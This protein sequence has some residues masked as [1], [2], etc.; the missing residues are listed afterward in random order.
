MSESH[1][2]DGA[3]PAPRHDRPRTAGYDL[4]RA[5]AL[6]GMCMVDVRGSLEVGGR[7]LEPLVWLADCL[8]G[9]AAAL[10]VVLAGIGISLRTTRTEDI[11]AHAPERRALLERAGILAGVGALLVHIWPSDILH[12][13]A[14]Y[15]LLALPLLQASSRTLWL[16]SGASMWIAMVLQHDLDWNQ[17]SPASPVGMLRHLSFSGLYPV[18]PWIAFVL[19]GMVVGRLELAD[20]RIRRRTLAIALT[21]ATATSMLDA[22]GCWDRDSGVLGLG[23]HAAWLMTWPRAP[24]PMFVISGCAVAVSVVCVCISLGER[25]R[26]RT[27]VTALVATGQL[28]L[29]LYVAHVLAIVVPLEHGLLRGL[30]IELAHAYA[31]AFYAVAIAFAL[32]WRRRWALGPLEGLMRQVIARDRDQP[33]RGAGLRGQ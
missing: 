7:G 19:V 4:A 2:D 5:A 27:W 32:W 11:Q 14:V 16:L 10:F 6:L 29:S 3:E 17:P 12:F 33:A 20:R 21:I 31:L 23:D 1:P 13:H 15:L 18:F 9:K 24:R 8:E 22:L 25:H 26:D 28:T 30:P